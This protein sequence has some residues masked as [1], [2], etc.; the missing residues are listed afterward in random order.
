MSELHKEFKLLF[1][2]RALWWKGGHLAILV[3]KCLRKNG[4]NATLTMVTQ[5]KA[6]AAWRQIAQDSQMDQWITWSHFLPREQLLEMQSSAH[7]FVYPT[8]HD[9]SSSALPEAYSTGMPSV[10]LGIGGIATAAGRGTGMNEYFPNA[11]QWIKHAAAQISN[12]TSDPES[13][14]LACQASVERSLY[15][16]PSRLET[17]FQEYLTPIF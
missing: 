6:E 14:F 12:W 5:G 11:Q 3:L 4:V 16:N 9:S 17:I 8:M 15:F 2:G 10:T 1:S 7:A 13:W